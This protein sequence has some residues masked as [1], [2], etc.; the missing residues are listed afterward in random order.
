MAMIGHEDFLLNTWLT[1]QRNSLDS[2]KFESHFLFMARVGHEDFLLDR[3]LCNR[4]RYS[5][6]EKGFV[7]FIDGDSQ[8]SKTMNSF[9]DVTVVTR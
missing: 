6:Q 2:T 1:S 5:H 8:V 7:S 4:I 3:L 9:R